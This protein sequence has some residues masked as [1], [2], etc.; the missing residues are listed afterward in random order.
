MKEKRTKTLCVYSPKGGTGKSGIVMSL[1]GVLSIMKKRVLLID[2]DLFNG[3]LSLLI[4]ENINK[5]IY[6]FNDDYNNNRYK[7]FNEYIYHYDDYIDILCAPKDPRQGNKIDSKYIDIIIEK[8]SSDYEYIIF[9]TSSELNDINLITMD[10]V[11]EILF[12]ITNDIMC[13]KNVRNILNIFKDS[14]VDNYRVV[15]NNTF[16]KNGYFKLSDIKKIIGSNIDYIL[17]SGFYIKEFNDKLYNN[18]IAVLDNILNR[19]HRSEISKLELIIKDID[20]DK[21]GV[22]NEEK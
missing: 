1:G 3:S 17:E 9:D 20:K 12:I 15:L 19:R 18:K 22:L 11:D 4:N 5:T 8:A 13:V 6:H 14:D 2:F 10:S 7:S 21:E 16:N